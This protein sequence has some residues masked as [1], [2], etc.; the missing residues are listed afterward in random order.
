M[1]AVALAV[2]F[3]ELVCASW[4]VLAM[5]RFAYGYLHADGYLADVCCAC[6][7]CAQQSFFAELLLAVLGC[8]LQG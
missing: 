1:R 5:L 2:C 4:Y 8:A 3:A 7:L 6:R